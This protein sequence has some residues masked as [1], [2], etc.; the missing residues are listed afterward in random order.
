ML[1]EVFNFT[2][3]LAWVRR[4]SCERT[5]DLVGIE[6]KNRYISVSSVATLRN[7]VLETY[8]NQ[9]PQTITNN[10]AIYLRFVAN[11]RK[12]IAPSISQT[13]E[14]SHIALSCCFS[15]FLD[16]GWAMVSTKRYTKDCNV[17]K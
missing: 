14:D 5:Y 16:D 11:L 2:G 9:P 13:T 6:E 3:N 4:G 7:L 1:F 15:T 8:D 10:R 12:L 17:P